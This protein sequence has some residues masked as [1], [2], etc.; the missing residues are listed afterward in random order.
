MHYADSGS[1]SV[2]VSVSV[3]VSVRQ[4]QCTGLNAMLVTANAVC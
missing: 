1:V 4:Y 2:N 3:S